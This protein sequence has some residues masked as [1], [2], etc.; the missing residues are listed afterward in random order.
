MKYAIFANS[1]KSNFINIKFQQV[2]F[3]DLFHKIKY[4]FNSF[5]TEVISLWMQRF[6][7]AGFINRKDFKKAEAYK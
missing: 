4:I 1:V 2:K 3:S 6:V 7:N 5:I